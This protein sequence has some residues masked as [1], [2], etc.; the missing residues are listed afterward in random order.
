MANIRIE[1]KKTNFIPILLGLLLLG[2]VAWA[3]FAFLDDE[4]NDGAL[5]DTEEVE[6]P[7]AEMAT[8]ITGQPDGTYLDNDVDA[9]LY[10]PAVTKFI[11][12]TTEMEGEM[13]LDHE[14]S[15][16]AITYLAEATEAIADAYDVN[17][18]DNTE[19]AKQLAD[20]ITVDPYATNH[21]EKIRM[22]AINITES[23]ERIDAT[24]FNNMNSAHIE[25]IR[26]EAQ[27]IDGATLTLNQKEDVRGFLKAAN[28]LMM[29][30]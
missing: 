18:T 5:L 4:D 21:A 1:E 23:L 27:A 13:G 10:Q 12:Y 25:T 9:T 29:K 14:F 28:K 8:E 2:L 17:L 20:E 3:G 26:E 15:H 19:R 24:A 30:M 22:A 11:T 7:L 6:A 16:N